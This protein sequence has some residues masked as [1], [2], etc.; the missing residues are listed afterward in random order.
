MLLRA[1]GDLRS[2]EASTEQP[3]SPQQ[4]RTMPQPRRG[5]RRSATKAVGK[6]DWKTKGAEEVGRMGSFCPAQLRALNSQAKESS[7]SIV[8]SEIDVAKNGES[9][10]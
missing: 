7:C 4:N 10:L 5:A 9:S 2:H 3:E 6:E 1:G 8:L